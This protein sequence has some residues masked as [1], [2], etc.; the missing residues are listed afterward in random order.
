MVSVKGSPLS[1]SSDGWIAASN[2]TQ[3][4]TN[5]LLKRIAA[6]TRSAVWPSKALAKYLIAD[7]DI[8]SYFFSS[9]L[10][11]NQLPSEAHDR[12]DDLLLVTPGA[13]T[14]YRMTTKGLRVAPGGVHIES[15]R[16]EKSVVPLSH[17]ANVHMEWES[18]RPFTGDAPDHDSQL[19][20]RIKL[21]IELP[22]LGKEI[23]LP[24]RDESD[25]DPATVRHQIETFA[26]ALLLEVHDE[27][28]PIVPIELDPD[29]DNSP[30]A[31]QEEG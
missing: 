3:V 28:Q 24:Y 18:K 19:H 23:R 31:G 22:P 14:L 15:Q 16:L 1:P 25:R 6:E 10:K 2:L 12:T 9:D 13:L 27:L 5:Q 29:L 26:E 4:H 21:D 8:L 11:P 30:R 20:L 7:F 17:L